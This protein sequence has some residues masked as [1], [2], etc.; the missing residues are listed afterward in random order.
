MA[1]MAEREGA[2]ALRTDR[3]FMFCVPSEGRCVVD[4]FAV[5][6]DPLWPTE[7]RLLLDA[8]WRKASVLGQSVVRVV[9]ARRDEPKR[10]ML[11]EAGLVVT[12]RWW[13]K[14]L[15]PTGPP[16]TWGPLTLLDV[17]AVMVAAPLVYDPGGPVCVLGGGPLRL[18]G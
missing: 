12:A 8:V 13:V 16:V 1:V 14:E 17:E 11:S 9:T 2:V 15:A 18:H 5:E 3:G 4:D 10:T 7:G 6:D